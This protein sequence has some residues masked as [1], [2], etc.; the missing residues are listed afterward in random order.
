MFDVEAAFL[1]SD[2][3]GETYIEWPEGMIEI[4]F[5]SEQE[6]NKYCI[7]LTKAMYGNIDAPLCWMKTFSKYLINTVGLTQS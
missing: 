2:V 7:K 4:G 6:K 3:E 1:N 5:I